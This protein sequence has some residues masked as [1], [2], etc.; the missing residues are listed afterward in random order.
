VGSLV[1]AP[2]RRQQKS[3]F[4][5]NSNFDQTHEKFSKKGKNAKNHQKATYSIS[6]LRF[7]Y[8]SR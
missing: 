4:F 6:F 7:G 3:L 8:F 1:Y 5:L 2:H